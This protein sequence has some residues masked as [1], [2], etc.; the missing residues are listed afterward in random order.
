[1]L[2]LSGTQQ[3]PRSG[4]LMLRVRDEQHVKSSSHESTL[5]PAII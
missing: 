4:I 2:A 5:L 1:M 3:T